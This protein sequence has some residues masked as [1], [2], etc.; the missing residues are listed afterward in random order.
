MEEMLDSLRDDCCIPYLDDILC[1]AKTFEAHLEGLR[2]VLKALQQHGVKLRPNKCEFFKR[3]VR[4]VGRLV[5]GEGVRIAPKDL[6]AILSLR[7]KSPSTIGEVRRLLGF[8]S[9]YRT[10]IQDFSRIAKP[11]YDLLQIKS[12]NA[13]GVME[14]S[15][16][17]KGKSNQL[18]SKTPVV[19]TEEHKNTLGTLID[20]LTHPPVL[21]YPDF[22]SPFT[23]HTDASEK[24][25][26]AVL[27]QWQNG[28]LR[29]IAYGSRTLTPAEKNYN[30]HS[31]K[32]EFLALKWAICEKFRDYLFYASHFTVY[33]D[34]NPLTYVMSTAKLMVKLNAVGHRWV[35]ELS[36]YNFDIKYRPG[37]ENIDADTLSRCP[38]DIEQDATCSRKGEEQND[39]KDKV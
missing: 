10:Y 7:E 30:L 16:K 34:N 2:R 23:L 8:L 26:G 19:W 12:N 4:Y 36:D 39:K 20:I 13:H 32:L 31:G 28:K 14:R 27:Y 1:Y 22:N 35:G 9:Y 38:L 29:V 15:N 24:G 3:E 5:S 11:I 25:L 6:N 18:P 21:A 17:T 37:K 33:T